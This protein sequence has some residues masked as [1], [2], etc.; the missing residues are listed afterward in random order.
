MFLIISRSPPIGG[1]RGSAVA[2]AYRTG[3]E[4]GPSSATVSMVRGGGCIGRAR[5]PLVLGEKMPSPAGFGMSRT[6]TSVWRRGSQL[7]TLRGNPRR[8]LNAGSIDWNFVR[9][10]SGRGD[11]LRLGD[12]FPL[13]LVLGRRFE[14]GRSRHP[15]DGACDRPRKSGRF[16]SSVSARGT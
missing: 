14:D 11:R 15:I 9:N 12:R 16:D 5:K 10:G 1:E 4:A 3:L 2:C 13:S 8:W 6:N 7:L